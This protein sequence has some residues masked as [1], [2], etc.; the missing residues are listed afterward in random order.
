MKPLVTSVRI[1]C[2]QNNMLVVDHNLTTLC[3][4]SIQVSIPGLIHRRYSRG[5]TLAS[6]NQLQNVYHSVLPAINQTKTLFFIEHWHYTTNLSR[7]KKKSQLFVGEGIK[8]HT[9][10]GSNLYFLNII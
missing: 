3:K 9:I 8:Q 6:Y 5:G 4:E 10:Y 7:T 1:F 2:S